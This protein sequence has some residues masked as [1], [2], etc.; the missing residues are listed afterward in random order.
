M[1]KKLLIL[2]MCLLTAMS[3][4][5]ATWVALDSGNPDIQLFIDNDSIKYNSNDQCVYAILYKKSNDPVKLAYIKSDY[6]TNKIGVIRVEDYEIDKYNPS[7]YAKHSR[8]FMKSVE[9]NNILL[10]AHNYAL[11]QHGNKFEPAYTN[12][13]ATDINTNSSYLENRAFKTYAE[14][15]KAKILKNWNTTIGTV[16]TDVNILISINMDGS[17]N[18][19]RVLDSNAGEKAK[20][21]AIAAIMLSAPFN[22]FPD[23]HLITTSVVNIPIHFEQKFFKNYVK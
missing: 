23:G 7:F 18:G 20:R 4:Q 8:A 2:A 19:Y 9:N 11:S 15:V 10:S 6:S 22:P 5:A 16:Y 13:I 21:T 14:D 3:A 12:N 17:L 1:K